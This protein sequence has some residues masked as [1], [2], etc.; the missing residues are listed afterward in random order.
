MSRITGGWVVVVIVLWGAAGWAQQL[1]SKQAQAL[2]R[3]ECSKCHG[4]IVSNPQGQF[5]GPFGSNPALAATAPASER[6][7]TVVALPYGPSLRGI[8]GRPAGRVAGFTYS[9]AF[10]RA[11]DG[12]VWTHDTLDEWLTSSQKRVP[13]A[14]MFYRQPDAEIRRQIIAYLQA[15]SP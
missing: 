3:A 5:D 4:F 6:L 11:L 15:H 8:Y 14:R 7:R 9:S 1:N 10:K 13:G 2:Y 12:V